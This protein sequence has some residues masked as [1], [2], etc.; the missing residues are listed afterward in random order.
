MQRVTV[1]GATF[2]VDPAPY[3]KFWTNVIEGIWEPETFDVFDA[4]ITPETLML[5]IGAWIGPTALYAAQ[6]AARVVAFEPDPVAFEQLGR[7]LELNHGTDWADRLEIRQTAISVDGEPFRLGSQR[8]GG[9][10]RSSAL[11]ADRRTSWEVSATRLEAVLDEHAAPGQP[12]F[13]KID[14][15]GG[16]YE[17]VPHIAPLLAEPHVTAYI[18]FHPKNL[19]KA[20]S[21]KKPED[22]DWQTP[23]VAKHMAIL[24]ALP[25]GRT[26]RFTSPDLADK[27]AVA[28]DLAAHHRFPLEV[29][30]A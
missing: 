18:S 1:R 15:E 24:D 29:L 30:I 8:A 7:N 19:M 9:D 3:E 20:L 11:F 26:L 22:F 17:L 25:D 27:A 4:H 2:S 21:H 16:E 14:I 12:L 13:L 23:F 5:D 6:K 28:A 10:S